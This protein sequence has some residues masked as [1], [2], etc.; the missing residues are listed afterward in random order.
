LIPN[1]IEC[2]RKSSSLTH[3]RISNWDRYEQS[4]ASNHLGSSPN[5]NPVNRSPSQT[6]SLM[7]AIYMYTYVDNSMCVL[8]SSYMYLCYR[9]T[10]MC[11]SEKSSSTPCQPQPSR[12]RFDC[13]IHFCQRLHRHAH[14]ATLPDTN[15]CTLPV[16][17]MS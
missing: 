9:R 10:Y 7:S 16:G 4:T 12:S 2:L 1:T 5:P 13:R 17:A 6:S 8:Q 3:L 15:G 14:S 11:H